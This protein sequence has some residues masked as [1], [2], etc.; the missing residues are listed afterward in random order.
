MC[1]PSPGRDPAPWHGTLPSRGAEPVTG[2][3]DEPFALVD[4]G[5]CDVRVSEQ[6]AD[7]LGSLP[8]RETLRARV[9]QVDRE[10]KSR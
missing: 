4:L 3:S 7:A 1:V 2:V 6:L 8:V 10:P 5:R 9:R